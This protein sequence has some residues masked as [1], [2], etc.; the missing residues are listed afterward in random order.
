MTKIKGNYEFYEQQRD[1]DLKTKEKRMKVVEKKRKQLE[2]FTQRFHAQPNRAAAVRN[3]RK[4]I[5]RLEN[6]E[7]P[8]EQKSI[9]EFEFADVPPSGYV[10]EHL[11][12]VSKSYGEK[13]VYADLDLEVLRGQK[14]CLV[15][16]NGAGKSTLLKDAGRCD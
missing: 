15:G 6:I 7:L 10:V 13:R 11:K 9:G 14:I 1:V 12:G 4:Q 16:P 2:R 5:E 8:Q 3:K